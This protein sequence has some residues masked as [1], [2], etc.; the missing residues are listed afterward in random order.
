MAQVVTDVNLN[1]YFILFFL[2]NVGHVL[3][4]ICLRE[5]EISFLP[6]PNSYATLIVNGIMC[7]MELIHVFVVYFTSQL[8][9]SIYVHNIK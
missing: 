7:T 8:L 3:F 2:N 9:L 6:S 5:T 1:F 4:I